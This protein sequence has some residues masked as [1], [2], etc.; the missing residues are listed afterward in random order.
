MTR[1][2]YVLLAGAAVLGLVGYWLARDAPP[3]PE[4][5]EV[6]RAIEAA[7]AA[8][9]SHRFGDLMACISRTYDDGRYTFDTLQGLVSY[10]LRQ[11]PEIQ[12]AVYLQD[13]QVRGMEAV[14]TL[15]VDAAGVSSGGER[16]SYRGTLE[17]RLAREPVRRYL[18]LPGRRWRITRVDGL[19][20]IEDA[21]GY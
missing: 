7:R 13:V 16:G 5:E 6:R 18:L 1:I 14:V 3:V 11:Y 21:F 19:P 17:V 20:G 12:V 2:R 8:I 10:G 4:E 15:E 9:V